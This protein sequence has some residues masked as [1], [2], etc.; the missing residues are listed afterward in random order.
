[1]SQNGLDIDS[2]KTNNQAAIEECSGNI[3][4]LQTIIAELSQEGGHDS[5]I[6]QLNQQISSLQSV[7]QLLSGNSFN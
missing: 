6:E 2:L 3:S 5:Q 7:I 4:S 1:M